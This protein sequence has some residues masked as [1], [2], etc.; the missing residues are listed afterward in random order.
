MPGRRS[1]RRPLW[2]L[3]VVAAVVGLSFLVGRA[4]LERDPAAV[5]YTGGGK[6]ARPPGLQIFVVRGAEIRVLQPGGRLHPGDLVRFAVRSA[7]PRYLVV[8]AR[9]G[10]GQDQ[11]LFPTTG[12]QAALVRSGE[13]L[14]ATLPIDGR[15]GKRAVT[16]LFAPEP[17]AVDGPLPGDVQVVS[18]DLPSDQ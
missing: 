12:S 6:G 8:R 2:W 4:R 5:A 9:L 11:V 16:A 7:E 14:P 15:P 1:L 13:G 10:G 18:I 3:A 17:F